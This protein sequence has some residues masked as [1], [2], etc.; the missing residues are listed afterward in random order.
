MTDFKVISKDVN[1]CPF[2]GSNRTYVGAVRSTV[3][4]GQCEDCLC[5]GPEFSY[6]AVDSGEIKFEWKDL[7][8][9]D[10]HLNK[11]AFKAWNKRK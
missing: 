6:D 8:D 9:L 7:N 2:C 11:L 5:H 3:F 1:S 10:N 4:A